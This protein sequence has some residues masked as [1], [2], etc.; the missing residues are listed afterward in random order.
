MPM[1]EM[2]E[3]GFTRVGEFHYLHHDIG[4]AP[5]ADPGEMAAR[6]AAASVTT[7]I[8][9]TLLPSLYT[10]GGFGNAAPN[11]GQVRFLN[12]T[13]RFLTLMARTREIV[14]IVPGAN[15]GIAPHSLRAVSPEQ[16]RAVTRSLPA[17]PGAYPCRRTDQGSGRL[18]RSARRAAGAMAAR[19]CRNR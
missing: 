16:L 9:L 1:C 4:G 10:Y 19:Q 2:L 5:Y 15:F 6:I 18:H 14:A 12:S 13:D 8:G 3:A 7:G 11:P 17:S